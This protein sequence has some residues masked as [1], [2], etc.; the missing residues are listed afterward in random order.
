MRVHQTSLMDQST[1]VSK[2]RFTYLNSKKH[3]MKVFVSMSML[4]YQMLLH[5]ILQ[6]SEFLTAQTYTLTETTP[7]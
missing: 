1:N 2:L 3:L 6:T 5:Q 7:R 4:S